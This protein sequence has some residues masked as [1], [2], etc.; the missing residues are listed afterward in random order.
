MRTANNYR[1]SATLPQAINR[2]RRALA[3]WLLVRLMKAL[4]QRLADLSTRDVERL[5]GAGAQGPS[6]SRASIRARCGSRILLHYNRAEEA[7]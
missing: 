5:G 4:G 3:L 6:A 1:A 7:R 2:L